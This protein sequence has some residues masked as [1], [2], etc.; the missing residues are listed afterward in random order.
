MDWIIKCRKTKWANYVYSKFCSYGDLCSVTFLWRNAVSALSSGY[1]L[2][3][4]AI[5]APVCTGRDPSLGQP[6]CHVTLVSP[7]GHLLLHLRHLLSH[8]LPHRPGGQL[9]SGVGSETVGVTFRIK[10]STFMTFFEDRRMFV[11]WYDVISSFKTLPGGG[12][13][14]TSVGL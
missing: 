1:S 10:S 13:Q 7:G 3:W 2:Y 6:W 5:R 8:L 9:G 4:P 12:P 14:G 11:K